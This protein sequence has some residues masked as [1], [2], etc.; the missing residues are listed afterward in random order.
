MKLED[1]DP[2]V[3]CYGGSHAYG[4]NIETSDIDIRG[5]FCADEK[6][7]RTP[8]H[9]VR[10]VDLEDKE[11]G[12][13]YELT[14]F[15]KLY[16]DMNPNILELLWVDDK[17][18]ITSTPEY[19]HLR[20][21]RDQ[22]LSTKAAFTFTGYAMQ[23]MKRIKG[24][25]KWIN[26][27]QPEKSPVRM[28]YFKLIHNYGETKLLPKE[29]NIKSFQNNHI[30]IPYGSDIYAVCEKK[31][32]KLFNKDGS[33]RKVSYDDLSLVEKKEKPL[34]I[35][36]LCESEYK[37]AKETHTNY[38]RWKRE[39]NEKRHALEENFGYDCYLDSKT[40]FLTN[41]G[42][43]LYDDVSDEDL[44]ATVNPQ[45]HAIEYQPFFDRVKKQYTGKMY[46]VENQNTKCI[47]TGNHR[48]F[49]SDV[50]RGKNKSTRYQPE[51]A[52]WNYKSLDELLA[53]KQSYYHILQSGDNLNTEY[54]ISDDL[55]K[56][57]GCYVTDGCLLKRGT[58]GLKGVSIAQLD[59]NRLCKFI[60][61]IT[62]Y[63]VHLYQHKRNSRV[64]NTY[65]IYNKGLA[66]FLIEECRE[67]SESKRLPSFLYK[68]SKR[69]AKLLRDVMIAGDGTHKKHSDIYYSKS[70]TLCDDFQILN[71][72]AGNVTKLWTYSDLAC[73]QIY[74]SDRGRYSVLYTEKH[75]TKLEVDKD[76]IV[77]FSVPNENLITRCDGKISVQGNTKHAMH[78]VRLM[79]MGEEILSNGVVNVYRP[80]AQE[81][82]DIRNGKWTY[83][84]LLSWAE[85]M[86]NLVR[87]KLYKTSQLPNKVDLNLASKVLMEVQDMC[88]SK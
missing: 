71:I 18:I 36:K 80:D 31:G 82:L 49:T 14:N 67:Y 35:A 76:N 58:G 75:V 83:E 38:W 43:K 27:P 10:E 46:S 33:L 44:L 12:K 51:D 88:W 39:R 15:M 87:N 68:L 70:K 66:N 56:I 47:V 30:L 22:L 57:V 4:T 13:L 9:T 48:M 61:S 17:S 40:Q 86:D 74:S 21:Y 79:R 11:D 85:D 34:F 62:E 50:H 16:V 64:E 63:K 65:N 84:E 42:F 5:I 25:N 26:N 24:H 29:F 78:I 28:D 53:R 3:T 54:P 69:Q 41:K 73:D 8:F 7:I 59:G 23:Q 32:S 37:Q 20:S 72:L 1:F 55:L 45:T 19:L 52:D 81:L 2:I 6:A 77:C 60:E